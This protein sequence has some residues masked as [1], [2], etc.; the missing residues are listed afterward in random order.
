MGTSHLLLHGSRIY[1]FFFSQN[2][3]ASNGRLDGART[4]KFCREVKDY[5]TFMDFVGKVGGIPPRNRF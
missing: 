2:L 4:M 5:P 3:T 1:D